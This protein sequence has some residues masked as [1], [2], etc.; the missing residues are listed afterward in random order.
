MKIYDAYEAWFITGSQN[1]YGAEVLRQVTED[2]AGIVA[3]VNASGKLPIRIIHKPVLTTPEA[4]SQLVQ[5]ANAAA[6]CVGLIAWMHTFSPAKMWI[7]G[8][9]YLQTVS[10]THLTLPTTPYV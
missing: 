3:G 2:S 7:R 10:Y 4:I 9:S 8:I 1:L 6:N 5:E